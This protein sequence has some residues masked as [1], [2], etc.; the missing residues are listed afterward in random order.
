LG[1][2]YKKST[3]RPKRTSTI[4][5]NHVSYLDPVVALVHLRPA[6]APAKDF[7]HVPL[8]GTLCNVVDSIFIPRGGSEEKKELAL[9]A[10]RER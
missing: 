3:N 10:I 2:D 9:A 6:L 5:S 4:V 7:E 8:V 1:P